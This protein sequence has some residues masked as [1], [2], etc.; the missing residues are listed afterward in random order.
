VGRDDVEAGGEIEVGWWGRCGW[1]LL[2]S[3]RVVVTWGY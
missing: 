2:V 3:R 1:D